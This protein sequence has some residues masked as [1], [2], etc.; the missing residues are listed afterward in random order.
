MAGNLEGNLFNRSDHEL[1]VV[2]AC[3]MVNLGQ[4]VYHRQVNC[5][6]AL[7]KH[8]L[9]HL[10]LNREQDCAREIKIINISTWITFS[11][12]TIANLSGV[13]N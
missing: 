13:Y 2:M 10:D 6:L 9:D 7:Q 5:Q 8:V 3:V 12:C 11:T 1:A 4:R